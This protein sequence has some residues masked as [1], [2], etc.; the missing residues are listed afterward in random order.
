MLKILERVEVN[1]TY[2]NTI[3]AT[4]DKPTAD[5]IINAEKLEAIWYKWPLVCSG[6]LSSKTTT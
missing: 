1:E 6:L 5:I 2:I 4:Y 3:R